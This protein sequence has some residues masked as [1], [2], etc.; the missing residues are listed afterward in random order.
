MGEWIEWSGG[1]CPEDAMFSKVRLRSRSGE[2]WE[3]DRG[4]LED[5]D[6]EPSD[7]DLDIVAYK[8]LIHRVPFNGFA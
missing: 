1:D 3:C 8:I 6:H 4:S 5:W 2:E 7:A